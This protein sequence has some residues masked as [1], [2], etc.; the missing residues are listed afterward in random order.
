MKRGLILALVLVGCSGGS[1]PTTTTVESTTSTIMETTTSTEVTTTTLAL[2]DTTE[3]DFYSETTDVTEASSTT[4][5]RLRC[6]DGYEN[7]DRDVDPDLYDRI[8]N[9]DGDDDGIKCETG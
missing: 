8:S 3:A 2:T 4:L 5:G 9:R 6:G 1:E 7:V